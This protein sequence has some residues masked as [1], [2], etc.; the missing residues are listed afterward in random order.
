[1]QA[2][3][4]T[5]KCLLLAILSLLVMPSPAAEEEPEHRPLKLTLCSERTTIV[6]GKPFTVGLL[7]QHQ[8]HHHSYFKF[9]GIVGVGTSIEW[10]LPEG[11]TASEI[12]WPVPEQVDM[13]GHG[14]Y[15]YH[16]DTLLLVDI[17]P[18]VTSTLANSPESIELNGK[19]GYMCCSQERC[20]PGFE[21]LSLTLRCGATAVEHP[22][23][24]ED[25][26]ATRKA[27]PKVFPKWTATINDN[28]KDNTFHLHLHA[29]AEFNEEALP[30][31]NDLYFFST[32]Q[33]T[34]SD[35]PHHC[36]RQ[37]RH[38]QFTLPKHPFPDE[39]AKRFQGIL[40]N[41]RGWDKDTTGML[42]DL[43]VP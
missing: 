38:Y 9:P 32:N 26:A 10:T 18:P 31:P 36:K 3:I 15:G 35:K 34:A 23:Y 30:E 39:N 37:G 24:T 17:T 41:T 22:S 2:T 6:P 33:W 29:P 8:P 20:T 13:R 4:A 1:M 14:A 27:H 40:R 7:L 5:R 11:Y 16:K 21:D 42:I 12:Q 28:P 19:V 25:F 43:S